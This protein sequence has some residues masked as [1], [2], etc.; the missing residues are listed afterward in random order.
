VGDVSWLNTTWFVLF[1]AIV[2][3]YLIMDG[4]DLGVGILH[5]L[6]GRSDG[7]RRVLLNSIGPV[8]DGNAVWLVV[9]GG[10]LF[11]VFPIVYAALFSGFY[12]AMMLVLL[13]LILRP[14]AIE[15]RSKL[16]GPRWRAL[17]DGV[18]AAASLG[19]ALLLGVAFGNIVAGVPL[20]SEGQVEIDGLRDLL[21]PLALLIGATTV[22]M[23]AV[24]G[25]LY[26]NLKTEGGLQAR[27]RAWLPRLMGVF[28]FLGLATGAAFYITA[29][30]VLAVYGRV[31]PLVFPLGAV[32]TFLG[33]W[34]LTR[35]GRPVLAFT[36]SAATIALVLFAVAVGMFP[37]LLFSSIDPSYSMTA[38]NAASAQ[39]T[40][41]VT[42]IVAL[43]GMPFVLAYTA[44][45]NYFF[46]GKVRLSPHSY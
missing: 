5:L 1:V 3:G 19:L 41:L 9:T 11:A 15:F 38:Y 46:L 14:V 45:V 43:I 24:H 17:W 36:C 42:F 44:G 13:T 7:E 30:P 2:A 12:G 16:E 8:W 21:Q 28:A 4:F 20:S 35:R 6:V 40:L 37:T 32:A 10:A 25:A 31:W 27:V 23:L 29:H 22:A 18:F 34:R 39:N 33:S 26:L